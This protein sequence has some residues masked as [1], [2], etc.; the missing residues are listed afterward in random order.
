MYL[1]QK[2]NGKIK[3]VKQILS[4]LPF[5]IVSMLD[6]GITVDVVEDGKTFEENAVKKHLKFQ[7][8]SGNITLADDS[9][10]EID[11][12]NK[13]TWLFFLHDI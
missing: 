2:N 3:E 11:F 6:A 8:V 1:Q 9:G 13:T 5:E 4:D 12:L 10:L 7:K